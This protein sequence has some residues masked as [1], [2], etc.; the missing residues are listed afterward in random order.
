[1][2]KLVI[3]GAGE[4]AE[5]A[6]EYFT[7]DSDYE[8]AAFAVESKYIDSE[9]TTLFN[10]PIVPFEELEQKYPPKEYETFVAITYVQL[11]KVR[12]RLFHAC[13]EK[14][15]TCASYVSSHSFFWHNAT[16]GE[17]SF[18]FEDNTIQYHVS[19]GNNV[20]LWSG[21]H[22]GHRTVIEDD[23]WLTSH[24]V[25]SGYCR[26]GKGSFLGVNATLGDNVTLG[27]DT[28]FGAGA[29]TVH[30]LPDKGCVYVGSPAKKLNRTSYE[31]FGVKQRNEEDLV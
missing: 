15:Y 4:F 8:V 9:K 18:I 12:A 20:I 29:L 19:I 23:C 21:N 7:R 31:Q 24:C 22:I 11:N 28:V 6:Y 30:S 16:I 25:V 27:E 17:N 13:K 2:K 1:M 26:I 14:G 3:V 5:I 10:L